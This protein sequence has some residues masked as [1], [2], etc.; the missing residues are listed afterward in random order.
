LK[1]NLADATRVFLGWAALAILPFPAPLHGAEAGLPFAEDFQSPSLLNSTD[2][3]AQWT[4]SGVTLGRARGVHMVDLGLNPRD[5]RIGN[6]MATTGIADIAVRDMDG[7]GRMDFIIAGDGGAFAYYVDDADDL[8]SIQPVRITPVASLKAMTF[9]DFDRDGNLDV[10]VAGDMNT[11]IFYRNNG[12]RG[13]FGARSQVSGLRTIALTSADMDGDGDLDLVLAERKGRNVEIHLN[14]G[15]GNFSLQENAVPTTSGANRALGVGD[16][17]G[18]RNMDIVLAKAEGLNVFYLSDG[19]GGFRDGQFLDH[20]GNKTDY[21]DIALGDVNNDGHLDIVV[22]VHK[23]Q[24]ILYLNDGNGGFGM[25]SR[26]NNSRARTTVVKLADMDGD[27]DLDIVE[28]KGNRI[29][30]NQGGTFNTELPVGGKANT[31]AV[32]DVGGEGNLALIYG[33]TLADLEIARLTERQTGSPSTSRFDAG[34]GRVVSSKVN[35]GEQVPRAVFL[36]ATT[37]QQEHTD[38]EYY[39]SNNGGKRWIRAHPGGNV[40]FPSEGNDLRWRAELKSRSPV[41]TTTLTRVGIEDVLQVSIDGN[42]FRD[43]GVYIATSQTTR[44]ASTPV[45]IRLFN[46]GDRPSTITRVETIGK[47]FV[48]QGEDGKSLPQPLP[49]GIGIEEGES[50]E[51]IRLVF[52]PGQRGIHASTLTISGSEGGRALP[53]VKVRLRGRGLAPEINVGPVLD[54]IRVRVGTSKSQVVKIENKGEESLGISTPTTT[55][56]QF[57]LVNPAAFPVTATA[58]GFVDI[59]FWFEPEDRGDTATTITFVS[60]AINGTRTRTLRGQGVAPIISVEHPGTDGSINRIQFGEV[61]ATH[62]S[63]LRHVIKNTGDL[64][65][66]VTSVTVQN[67]W[68][69]VVEPAFGGAFSPFREVPIG[70]TLALVVQF[71]PQGRATTDD[72]LFIHSDA[73][74]NNDVS[75]V[76]VDGK[77]IA[78]E[79]VIHVTEA[80]VTVADTANQMIDSGGSYHFGDVAVN[81]TA[82]ARVFVSNQRGDALL[83]FTPRLDGAGSFRWEE[84]PGGPGMVAVQD[85]KM[86]STLVLSFAPATHGPA[87]ATLTLGDSNALE[88]DR[89]VVLTGVGRGAEMEVKVDGNVLAAGNLHHLGEIRMDEFKTIMVEV[90]NKGNCLMPRHSGLLGV[91]FGDGLAWGQV[92]QSPVRALSVVAAQPVQKMSVEAAQVVGQQVFLKVHQFLLHSPVEAFIIGVHLRAFWISVAM[93]PALF[94]GEVVE[95]AG[96]LAAIV[97]EHLLDWRREH[98]LHETGKAGG[99][100]AVGAWN[101]NGEGKTAGVV[102]RSEDVAPAAV[103]KAHDG[104]K[105]RR[106]RRR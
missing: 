100:G 84:P 18:D 31:V 73:F 26:I 60:N 81:T 76:P 67:P 11:V 102:G 3:T 93:P 97:C 43:G 10:A 45:T 13:A 32:G 59:E 71:E 12:N 41:R 49:A 83:M 53:D 82:S 101:G 79:M 94:A 57:S 90:A 65:L 19:N 7:N 21:R 9:G 56:P 15:R 103:S 72:A 70:S 54:A 34:R 36:T 1:L 88:G 87:S 16:L 28:G 33:K 62:I 104:V 5:S 74:N 39:L 40:W 46:R 63:T 68:F 23:A 89:E 30:L 86:T 25:G 24:N 48:L 96:E 55:N 91:L 52:K 37:V 92:A 85:G 27:G 44:K 4:S 42:A 14:D 75:P 29:Y 6:S 64:P 80:R 17:N 106:T 69:E 38:I 99:I 20:A 22:G 50:H 66:I 47:V 61:T 51:G 78:A 95:G 8:E 2:T 98:A 58:G 77:G 35:G 105:G